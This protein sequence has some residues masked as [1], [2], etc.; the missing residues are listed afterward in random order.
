VDPQRCPYCV[1]GN[2]F[3]PMTQW[4]DHLLCEKCGHLA[5]PDRDDFQCYC[6]KC[7]EVRRPLGVIR[8]R[9]FRSAHAG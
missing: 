1:E 7:E 3:K 8:V 4:G 9:Q 5:M 6:P 2:G